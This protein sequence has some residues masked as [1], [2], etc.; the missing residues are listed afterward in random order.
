MQILKYYLYIGF[1]VAALTDCFIM[2]RFIPDKIA[3]RVVN[4]IIIIFIWPLYLIKVGCNIRKML[5]IKQL[6][7]KGLI[8]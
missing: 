3:L 7:K 4:A 8:K 2:T 6:K 5:I 1:A